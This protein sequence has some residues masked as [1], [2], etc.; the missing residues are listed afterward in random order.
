MGT[1]YKGTKK[2]I[3]VLDTYIKF[4]RASVSLESQLNRN[5]T[6][7]KLTH[8]QFGVLE[9]LY[10]LGPL[11]QKDIAEK[12]LSSNSNLVTV[13]DNLE[14]SDLVI[15][16][17]YQQDRRN[18]IIHLTDKGKKLIADLFPKHLKTISERFNTLT[19]KEIE[20]LGKLCKKIGLNAEK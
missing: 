17:R 4:S 10:H 7:H 11:N 2:E 13:I 18:F 12:L 3:K 14:K 15:R 9:V 20:T 8:S 5:L 6:E 19:E 1:K 16:E